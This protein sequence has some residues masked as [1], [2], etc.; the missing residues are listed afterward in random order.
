MLP[1]VFVLS[2]NTSVHISDDRWTF[3]WLLTCEP[4]ELVFCA[5]APPTTKDNSGSFLTSLQSQKLVFTHGINSM[6]N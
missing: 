4:A 2:N 1:V 3:L 6:I 5:L